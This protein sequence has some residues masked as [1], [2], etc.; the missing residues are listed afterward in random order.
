[1]KNWMNEEKMLATDEQKEADIT[2]PKESLKAHFHL[3]AENKLYIEQTRT[4]GPIGNKRSEETTRQK[5]KDFEMKLMNCMC[6]IKIALRS[7]GSDVNSTVSTDILNASFLALSSPLE[8]A[9]YRAYVTIQDSLELVQF[10]N[11]IY[12]EI[13]LSLDDTEA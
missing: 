6:S 11:A 9:T 13:A 3:L 12:K 8:N 7:A 5:L 2:M 4:V 1:M 10:L